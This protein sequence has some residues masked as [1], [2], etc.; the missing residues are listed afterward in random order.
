[1][2]YFISSPTEE[3]TGTKNRKLLR[4]RIE[5]GNL[6]REQCEWWGQIERGQGRDIRRNSSV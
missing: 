2:D 4:G 5:I 1:L 6:Y 3:A